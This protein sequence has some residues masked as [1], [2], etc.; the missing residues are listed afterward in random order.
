[1][2][3]ARGGREESRPVAEI[4]EEVRSLVDDG[5]ME[6]TLLGQNI[7]SYGRSLEG[8]P[9]MPELLHAVHEVPGLARIR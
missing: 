1:M 4:V 9:K 7:N 6:V 5:V 3:R 8:R 2:P